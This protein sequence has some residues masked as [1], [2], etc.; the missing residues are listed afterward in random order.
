MFYW[1]SVIQLH[2]SKPHGFEVALTFFRLGSS[3]GGH[4]LLLQQGVHLCAL[5]GILTLHPVH[6]ILLIR[7]LCQAALLSLPY[8]ATM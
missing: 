3:R 6:L 5:I 4:A 1:R 8:T 2:T 7:P